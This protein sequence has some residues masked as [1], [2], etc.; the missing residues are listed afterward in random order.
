MT[1]CASRPARAPPERMTWMVVFGQAGTTS[2]S[3][4]RRTVAWAS[5]TAARMVAR[6]AGPLRLGETAGTRAARGDRRAAAYDRS[7]THWLSLEPL[8]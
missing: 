4:Q 2:G 3:Y 5:M 7:R 8:C 6:L 1:K